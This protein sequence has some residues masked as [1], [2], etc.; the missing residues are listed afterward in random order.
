MKQLF[1]ICLLLALTACLPTPI[2]LVDPGTLAAQTMAAMPRTDTPTV[3]LLASSIPS[4][5]IDTRQPTPEIN[6]NATGSYCI[7]SDTQRDRALVTKVIDGASIEVA[8]ELGNYSVRYI[9]LD[10]PGITPTLEWQAPQAIA[11]NERLVSG[12]YV[13]LVKDTTDTD[14]DGYY[15]RYVLVD[16]VFV[17]YDQILKGF[18]E[19]NIIPPNTACQDVFMSAM[20]QA[21]L[22]VVGIWQA[23]PMPTFTITSTATETPIATDTEIPQPAPCSCNKFYSCNNFWTQS[24][25]QE[26]YDY[27]LSEGYGPVLADQNNNG[28]VCEGLP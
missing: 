2:T 3:D 16:D 27:C 24:Q 12:K 17:N 15:L 5:T 14:S 1:V 4:P 26:C 20:L 6:P 11:A 25:A 8:T 21:Q 18:A 22:D 10:A 23:T 9:G 7:P 19:V 13:T 28:L